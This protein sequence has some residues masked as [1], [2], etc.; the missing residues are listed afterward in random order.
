M[1]KLTKHAEA[2]LANFKFSRFGPASINE[3]NEISLSQFYNCF[4]SLCS[5]I[6]KKKI[7]VIIT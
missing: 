6:D 5:Q 7:L 1:F 3:G 4:E 2:I